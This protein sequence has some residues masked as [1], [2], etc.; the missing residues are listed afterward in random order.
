MGLPII[1]AVEDEGD[2][3]ADLQRDLARRYSADYQV[4]TTD[5]PERGLELLTRAAAWPPPSATGRSPSR[6]RMN[7]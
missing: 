6:W 2:V 4:L 7:T 5:S 1:I 3:R